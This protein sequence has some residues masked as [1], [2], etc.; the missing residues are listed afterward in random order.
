MAVKAQSVEN[1]PAAGAEGADCTIL[2][3]EDEFLIRTSVAEELRIAGFT[4]VEASNAD[5]ALSV[6]QAG[7]S[8]EVVFTDVKM[9][10][11]IDGAAFARRVRVEYPSVKVFVTSG[12]AAPELRKDIH[13]FL[14]KPYQ[15]ESVIKRIKR[16][17][18]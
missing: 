3:V 18:E 9:P 6:L 4:V 1:S 15:I 17:M 8:I 13:G 16:V 10:G 7:T 5:D 14:R 12:N 11:S 2:L